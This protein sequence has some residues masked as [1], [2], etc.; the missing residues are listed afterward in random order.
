MRE[1]EYPSDLIIRRGAFIWARAMHNPQFDNGDNSLAGAF[2]QGLASTNATFAATKAGDIPSKIAAFES[3]LVA[4]LLH[5]RANDGQPM[6]E[7]DAEWYRATIRN[8]KETPT[9][10]WSSSLSTDYNPDAA[11]T[12]AADKSGLPRNM[13]SW[14]SRV[15][16]HDGFVS[17]SFGYGAGDVY[18]Y[19]LDDGR[20][21]ITDLRCG[22][23]D[24]DI[25]KIKSAAIDGRLD[26][27]IEDAMPALKVLQKA[28][29]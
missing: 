8:D 15:W 17:S 2:G 6:N 14:K 5:V 1:R 21:L 4:H 28:E 9:Y 25:E 12:Y 13:F 26:M 16:L 10:W 18:H 11:L 3:E 23:R 22:A 24:S 20:W 19:P 27:R 7:A 29:G